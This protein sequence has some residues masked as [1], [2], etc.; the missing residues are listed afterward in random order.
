MNKSYSQKLKLTCLN[1][2]YFFV[3]IQWNKTLYYNPTTYLEKISTK[4]Y[5]VR[6]SD[7]YWTC[8]IQSVS[9]LCNIQ[10]PNL[11]SRVSK[12]LLSVSSF[13]LGSCTFNLTNLLYTVCLFSHTVHSNIRIF[14]DTRNINLVFFIGA[15]N[16]IRCWIFNYTLR[17]KQKAMSNN[18]VEL[19]T[20]LVWTERL[21]FV[22]NEVLPL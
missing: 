10:C 17:N 22:N 9:F 15:R 19:C 13:S 4:S 14:R 8:I 1:T 11:V 12:D 18:N 21:K 3:K 20:C 7:R 2:S 6:L 5:M 16:R